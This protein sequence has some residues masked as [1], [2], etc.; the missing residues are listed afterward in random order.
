MARTNK[1]TAEITPEGKALILANIEEVKTMMPYLIN[2]TTEERTKL[3]GIGNKNLAYVQKCLE[4]ALA[5]PSEL[6]AN[7]DLLEF[8]RDVT[9][10]NNLVAIKMACLSLVELVDDSMK[11]TGIDAMG[12]AS[13]VYAA[14]KLAAK[15]NANV[16]TIVDEIGARFVA[17][18]KPRQNKSTS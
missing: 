10:F 7:F 1:I 6:K 13:E 11:A 8:Q 12:A 15:N 5:N 3:K 18:K 14:L 17:Q 9:L 16:K 2:L 4:A